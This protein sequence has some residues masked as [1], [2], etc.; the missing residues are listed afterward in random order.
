MEVIAAASKISC[1]TWKRP[2]VALGHQ[3]PDMYE[4]C[5]APNIGSIYVSIVGIAIGILCV[6]ILGS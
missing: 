3:L 1:T 2:P 4:Y 6:W 5:K